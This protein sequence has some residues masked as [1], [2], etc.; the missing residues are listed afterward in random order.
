MK[1][2]LLGVHI[3]EL[4]R[5]TGVSLRSLRYYEEKELL[6]PERLDNGYREYRETDIERVRLIQM[7]FSLGLTVKEIMSFFQCAFDEHIKIECLPNAIEVGRRKLDDIQLQ[8]D[9]L[10]QAELHLEKSIA[11]WEAI[12]HKGDGRREQG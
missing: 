5:K 3:S 6:R 11:A 4:S 7:Y 1:K 12:L 10:K 8:M 2:E 9:M